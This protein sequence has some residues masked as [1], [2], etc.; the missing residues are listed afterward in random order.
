MRSAPAYR[1]RTLLR[2]LGLEK[3][4]WHTRLEAVVA[5]FF[6]HKGA[7]FAKQKIG[8]SAAIP[9]KGRRRFCGISASIPCAA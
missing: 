9:R 6:H 7:F 8:L 4:V 3:G 2:A 1:K 5:L